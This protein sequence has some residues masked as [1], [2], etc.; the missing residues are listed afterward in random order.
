MM[1]ARRTTRFV[2]ALALAGLLL[3]SSPLAPA[4][5][6]ASAQPTSS[7]LSEFCGYLDQAITYLTA[8]P[9]PLNNFLLRYFVAL[10]AR[11][12]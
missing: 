4:S 2:A 6:A 7:S 11:Y 8:H 3:G 1:A 9:S 10:K 5:L 12:C